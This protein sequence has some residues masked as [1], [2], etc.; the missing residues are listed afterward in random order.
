MS[1]VTI[2]LPISPGFSTI[3]L[4]NVILLSFFTSKQPRYDPVTVGGTA[5][6][7][8]KCISKEVKYKRSE[9]TVQGAQV[10]T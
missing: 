5:K 4:S 10:R 2:D 7:K 8:N 9:Y 3:S 6:L 1:L